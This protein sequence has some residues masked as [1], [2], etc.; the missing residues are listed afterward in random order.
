MRFSNIDESYGFDQAITP[1]IGSSDF[2]VGTMSDTPLLNLVG[3]TRIGKWFFPHSYGNRGTA[4]VYEPET[5]V[6]RIRDD[7]EFTSPMLFSAHMTL[8][9]WPY[10]WRAPD[11]KQKNTDGTRPM[12]YQQAV[13]RADQQFGEILAILEKRG[14]LR[15]A[16]VV[17]FSDHGESFSPGLEPMV[18]LNDPLLA[19]MQVT[20]FWGHGT[21]VLSPHQF[22]IFLAMRAYGPAR[23]LLAKA[24]GTSEVAAHDRRHRAHDSGLVA[25]RH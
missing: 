20:P 3:S 13:R 6:E 9:H 10:N 8:P 17:A 14:L 18:P 16:I 22:R 5:F 7:V 4:L 12:F 11:L 15:N 2:I 23:Q 24:S 25:S 21:S 19:K 1:P